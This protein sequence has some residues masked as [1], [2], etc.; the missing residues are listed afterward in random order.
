[1]RKTIKNVFSNFTKTLPPGKKGLI[2]MDNA[3][4]HY[5][6]KNGTIEN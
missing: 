4:A 1:M 5:D 2:L 6:G 3:K